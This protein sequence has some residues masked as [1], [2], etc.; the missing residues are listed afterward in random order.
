METSSMIRNHC[1]NVDNNLGMAV[2]GVIF[3]CLGS[4]IFVTSS[5]YQVDANAGLLLVPMCLWLSIASA[6]VYSIWDINP[7]TKTGE[8]QPLVPVK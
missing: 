7:D 3:G 1:N 4:G 5:Y 8:R 2:P 6:L